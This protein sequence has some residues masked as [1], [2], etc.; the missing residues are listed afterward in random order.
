MRY[1]KVDAAQ[2]GAA[3][4]VSR[5]TRYHR[6]LQWG[7]FSLEANT[8][9]VPE[10]GYFFLLRDGSVLLRSEDFRT[11]EAAYRDLCR[12]HWEGDLGSGNP[13]R[14]LAS[15]WGLLSDQPTHPAAAAVVEQ[16]GEVKDHE[17][18]KRVRNRHRYALATEARRSGSVR[19]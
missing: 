18:L 17:R 7:D 1:P 16:D 14:R 4:Q 11:A 6:H 2:A 3:V 12:H 19:R 10:A 8:E 9:A 15:A 13:A 5:W